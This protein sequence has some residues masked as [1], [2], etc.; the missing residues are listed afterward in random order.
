MARAET[1]QAAPAKTRA[2]ITV[3]DTGQSSAKALEPEALARRDGWTV[4]STGKTAE[5]FKGDAVLDNGRITAVLRRADSGVQVYAVKPGGAVARLRLCLMTAGGEPAARLEHM[6]LVENSRSGA[7]LDATFKTAT[8]V[9]VSGRFR[10]KRGDDSVQA[11]PATGAGK[12]RV[13]CPGRFGIL[14]DFFADD[15]TIDATRLP[16]DA[17]ELPSENFV[18]QLSG[19]GDAIAMSVFENRR[20]DVRVTLDGAGASRVVTG[21]EIAF[22]DKKI[23]VTLMEA[24]QIWHVHELSPGDAG[25]VIPLDWKMPFP[26]QWRV[27]FTRSNDLTDSWVMLLQ[28]QTDG[29][30]KK[31]SWLAQATRRS[32]R[33]GTAGTPCWASFPT[34]AGQTRT[35]MATCS[36]SRRACS[37][38][39]GRWS[40]IRSTEWHRRRSTATPSST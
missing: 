17:V 36:R 18:L 11:E 38:F 7:C 6:A 31:P 34:R 16:L 3:C 12:L 10:I 13:E 20:Q 30:Y 2:G 32:V 39:K 9:S 8:G 14:P 25:K 26:A 22:E 15:I 40:C 5:S 21:S 29:K 19:G 37:S 28:E 1:A 27:D 35:G 24:P 23:W 33:I 4:I